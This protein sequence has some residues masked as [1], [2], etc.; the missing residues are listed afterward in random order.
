MRKSFSKLRKKDSENETLNIKPGRPYL[1]SVASIKTRRTDLYYIS[2]LNTLA[3][4]IKG[5]D[6]VIIVTSTKDLFELGIKITLKKM[7]T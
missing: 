4:H 2:Y 6:F 1:L 5:V 7:C 3:K